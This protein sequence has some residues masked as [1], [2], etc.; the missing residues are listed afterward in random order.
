M[1]H[2]ASVLTTHSLTCTGKKGVGLGKR[3]PSPSLVERAAKV[4]KE[5]EQTKHE[6]FRDRT[7]SA[8]E[9]RKIMG[10]LSNATKT[11]QSLDEKSGVEVRISRP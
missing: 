10:Q 1:K 11:L 8:F 7:R 4:L 3:A 6:S 5:E 9:E 2:F